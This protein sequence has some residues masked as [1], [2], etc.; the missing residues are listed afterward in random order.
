MLKVIL[1]VE[2]LP[3]LDDITDSIAMA[4]CHAHANKSKKLL[5]KY[6]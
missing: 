3:S 2:K 1:N 4:V 5:E 6:M